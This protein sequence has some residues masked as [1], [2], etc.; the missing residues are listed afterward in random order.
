MSEYTIVRTVAFNEGATFR[1]LAFIAGKRVDKLLVHALAPRVFF[2]VL[3]GLL[4]CYSFQAQAEAL[5]LDCGPI[6]QANAQQTP[7]NIPDALNSPSDGG[8][9]G[10]FNPGPQTPQGWLEEARVV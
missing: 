3:L 7:R 5:C 1:I 2:A 9:Y 4:G 8:I 10:G 6:T